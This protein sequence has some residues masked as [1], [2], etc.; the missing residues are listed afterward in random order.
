M[1]RTK[2]GKNREWSKDQKYEIINY[3]INCEKWARDLECY[4]GISSGILSNWF[5][6]YSENG[7]EGSRK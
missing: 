1:G 2:G 4:F 7:M 5:K 3:I 6:R